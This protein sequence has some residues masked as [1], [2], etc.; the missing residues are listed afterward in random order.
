VDVS[1]LFAYYPH[2]K[3]DILHKK[4]RNG[5]LTEEQTLENKQLVK[6]RIYVEHSMGGMKRY[7]ILIFIT[8][9]VLR[10]QQF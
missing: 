5:S 7:G 4:L 10:G 6:E 1:L 9:Y 8:V 2:L 3:F